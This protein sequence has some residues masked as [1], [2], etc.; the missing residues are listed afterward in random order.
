MLKT[1]VSLLSTK[2]IDEQEVIT[3]L[4]FVLEDV[5]TVTNQMFL[6]TNHIKGSIEIL[7]NNVVN[8][9]LHDFKVGQV[10][11]FIGST[12]NNYIYTIK[13]ITA[14]NFTVDQSIQAEVFYGYIVG[15]N[16]SR[17]SPLIIANMIGYSKTNVGEG[18]PIKSQSLSGGYSVSYATANV[19][20]YPP[21]IVN[22]L[23]S[24]RKLPNDRQDYLRYGY[25][26][27]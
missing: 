17:V 3:M 19:G 14:T 11:E 8:V 1:V 15:L 26:V 27:K 5:R 20:G 6:T 2:G 7:E 22:G 12:V 25:P 10:I 9:G 4:P 21:T 23:N 24:L 13:A 18:S 16:F